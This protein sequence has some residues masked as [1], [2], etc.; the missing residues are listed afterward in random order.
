M[1]NDVLDVLMDGEWHGVAEL[2]E[3]VRISPKKVKLVLRFLAKFGIA[4]FDEEKRVARATQ[5]ALRWLRGLRGK[6]FV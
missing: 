2:A 6:S 4:E 5:P 1:I 3:R